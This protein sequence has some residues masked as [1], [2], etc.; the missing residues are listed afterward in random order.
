M[1]FVIIVKIIACDNLGVFVQ[2]R[3]GLLFG[4]EKA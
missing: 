4:I 2:A 3:L 1:A